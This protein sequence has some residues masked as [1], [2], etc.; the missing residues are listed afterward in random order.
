M[1]KRFERNTAFMLNN[2]MINSITQEVI[3]NRRWLHENAEL[4]FKELNTADYIES[5]DKCSKIY[6]KREHYPYYLKFG[7]GWSVC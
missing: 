5:P 2:E 1:I 7:G 4:S 3:Q 6:R